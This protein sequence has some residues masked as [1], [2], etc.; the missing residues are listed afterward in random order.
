MIYKDWHHYS[1]R[2]SSEYFDSETALVYYNNR[3]YS[4]QLGRWLSRDPIEEK[5]G[6]NLYNFVKNNPVNSFDLLGTFSLSFP[7]YGN[8]GGPGWAAGQK[9]EDGWSQRHPEY[10][11]IPARD[12]LDECYKKHDKCYENCRKSHECDPDGE[13]SCFSGCDYASFSCQL[14]AA[15]KLNNDVPWYGRVQGLVAAGVLPAQGAVRDGYNATVVS[16]IL[17]TFD[18]D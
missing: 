3:Y 4:P 5:D 6:Y 18:S 12:Q 7:W 14:A 13:A 17:R 9:V 1:F 15:T 10:L 2:F 11:D 16:V 8:W